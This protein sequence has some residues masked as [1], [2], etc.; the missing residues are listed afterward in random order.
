D[1]DELLRLAG[2]VEHASEHPVARAVVAAAP[3]A[4]PPVEDFLALPGLGAQGVVEGRLVLVGRA[5]LLRQHGVSEVDDAGGGQVA[6][7]GRW[8][9]TISV[10][11]AVTPTS[12]DA[13]RRL[14]ELGLRPVLLT[15]DSATV[16]RSV[17]AATGID[18]VVAEVLPAGKVVE[19]QR[20]RAAGHV[21][22]MVRDRLNHPPPP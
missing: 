15:G 22:A 21:V 12:A 3:L 19:V 1:R 4:L 5:S 2:A 14:K 16:A 6:W 7:H 13:V 20:L 8:R 17:A 18:E 9:G 11:D 10:E